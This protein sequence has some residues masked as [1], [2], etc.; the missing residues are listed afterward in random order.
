MTIFDCLKEIITTKRGDLCDHPDFNK[1]WST[2]MVCRYLSMDS[3]FF[4]ISQTANRMQG[5]LSNEQ[6]YTFL[7]KHIP[8]QRS[9]Y[10][11]YITKPKAKKDSSLQS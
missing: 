9:S 11:K 2:F 4:D 7:V 10:I 1:T 3:R 5:S 6:V 8:K